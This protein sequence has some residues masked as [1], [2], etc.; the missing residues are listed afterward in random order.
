MR[1]DSIKTLASPEKAPIKKKTLSD[2]YNER[3][4]N[5][6]LKNLIHLGYDKDQV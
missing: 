6:H 2:I 4:L 5:L 3:K 1:A